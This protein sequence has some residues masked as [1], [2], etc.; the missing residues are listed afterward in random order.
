MGSFIKHKKDKIK[1]VFQTLGSYHTEESFINTFKELY[2]EDWR[3]IQDTWLYEERCTPPG[4]GHPMR[5]PDVYMK[6][7]YPNHKP[8]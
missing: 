1:Q 3:K 7:M 5:H 6:E 4:K 8:H 2:P